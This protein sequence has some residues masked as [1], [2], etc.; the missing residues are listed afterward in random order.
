M[1]TEWRSTGE[2]AYFAASNSQNGFTC[3]YD[4]C[5]RQRVD[6]LY[7][8]KGGPGTGKSRLLAEIA[9]AGERRGYH[10]ERYYC[11]S[12]TR[13]LDG[14]VLTRADRPTL[15]FADATAP[16][17]IEPR[18][19]GLREDIIDLGQFWDGRILTAREAEILTLNEQKA[20]AYR[21]AYRCLAGAGDLSAN[22][23]ELLAP[24]V[25]RQKLARTAARLLRDVPDEEV[26]SL[27]PALNGAISLQGRVRLDTYLRL[28]KRVCLI[29]DAFDVG[30]ELMRALLAE[31]QGKGLRCRVSYHP[32]LPDAIDALLLETSGTVFLVGAPGDA[33]P[34]NVRFPDRILPARRMIS[35]SALRARREQARYTV[36][37]R[38]ALID[39]ACERLTEAQRAHFALEEIYTA[40][41]DFPA[42]EAFTRALITRLFDAP[43]A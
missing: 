3:Y 26:F 5:I 36:R 23:H 11:S 30:Y 1:A 12:D 38:E 33:F 35:A 41:M 37:L 27:R 24:C 29:E 42:K 14:I 34:Q 7:C 32:L 8:V 43:N 15:G 21:M 28:G 16:H 10:A 13:S 25:D 6:H 22:L 17:V 4:A 2:D 20:T 18:L 9:R 19:P 39:S 31:A 40:A